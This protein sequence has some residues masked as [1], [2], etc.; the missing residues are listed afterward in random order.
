MRARQR[1]RRRRTPEGKPGALRPWTLC[2]QG[3]A[4]KTGITQVIVLASTWEQA[5]W[6]FWTGQKEGTLLWRDPAKPPSFFPRQILSGGLKQFRK[7]AREWRDE[8]AQRAAIAEPLP[9]TPAPRPNPTGQLALLV[10]PRRYRNP[11][12]E[13]Y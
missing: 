3:Y 1:P 9:I 8:V 6:K 13:G 7:G 5:T 10:A 11:Q 4:E 12:L 2:H